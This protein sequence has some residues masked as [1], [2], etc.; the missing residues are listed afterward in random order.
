MIPF[1][2]VLCVIVLQILM[3]AACLLSCSVPFH[4][5]WFSR[6]LCFSAF[7]CIHRVSCLLS[8]SDPLRIHRVSR[9]LCFTA[10]LR[11]DWVSRLL[12]LSAPQ[13]IHWVFG[14]LFFCPYLR[15]KI[16]FRLFCWKKT[17]YQI[18]LISTSKSFIYSLAHFRGTMDK[19][20]SCESVGNNDL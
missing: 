17:I 7:L 11:I 18:N 12:C 3:V 6:L 5:R 13:R 15:L 14:L 8:F 20:H 16:L 1:Y 4:V 10:P 9:L 2:V 19:F